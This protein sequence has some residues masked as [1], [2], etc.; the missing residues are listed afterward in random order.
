[1]TTEQTELDAAR[2]LVDLYDERSSKSRR[3][4]TTVHVAEPA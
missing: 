4:V 2:R 3:S 1:M